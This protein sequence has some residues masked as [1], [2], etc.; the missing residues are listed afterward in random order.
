M[1]QGTENVH[2]LSVV[3][4]SSSMQ[5]A[6][7]VMFVCLEIYVDTNMQNKLKKKASIMI[8]HRNTHTEKTH[9]TGHSTLYPQKLTS[10]MILIIMRS[11]WKSVSETKPGKVTT[12]GVPVGN[13]DGL[14]FF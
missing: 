12:V 11:F 7:G 9:C 13:C 3:S 14:C 6:T 8:K 4:F 10:L 5:H 2:D 1:Y